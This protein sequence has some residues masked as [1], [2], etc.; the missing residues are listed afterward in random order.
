MALVLAALLVVL[1]AVGLWI[2]SARSRRVLEEHTITPEALHALLQARQEVLLFDVRQPLDLLADS[3]IIP[4]AKRLDPEKVIENPS[5]IPKQRDAVVYCTCPSDRTARMI[6][7]KALASKFLR[8]KF[9][10]GGLNA[11]KA[12]GYP[13]EP[14]TKPFHLDTLA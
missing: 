10:R 4:G 2:K 3:E 9:L 1:V 7:Q 6:L 11:W 12:K 5:L 13:V 8:V 14:Y